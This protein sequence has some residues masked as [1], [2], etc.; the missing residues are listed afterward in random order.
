MADRS[1][2][3]S[4][5]TRNHEAFQRLL[6][7]LLKSDRGRV[8]LLRSGKL[9]ALCETPL[10]ALRKGEGMYSDGLFS[11]QPIIEEAAEDAYFAHAV[12]VVPL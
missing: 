10:E 8:A 12:T 11:V 4:E 1:A 3:E 5:T 2:A 9:A 7:G 6:P